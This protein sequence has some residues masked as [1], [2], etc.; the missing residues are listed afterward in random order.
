MTRRK[1]VE[2]PLVARLREDLARATELLHTSLGPVRAE[3]DLLHALGVQPGTL[4]V[5]RR[6]GPP[7]SRA[8]LISWVLYFAENAEARH[9]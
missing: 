2:N 9:A 6:Q 8:Q 5:W 1:V 7:A 3:A 4:A